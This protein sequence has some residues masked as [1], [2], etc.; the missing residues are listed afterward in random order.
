MRGILLYGSGATILLLA[1]VYAGD[2]VAWRFGLPAHRQPFG[3]VAVQQVYVI[4]EKSGKTEYQFPPPENQVCVEALFPHVGYSP[5]W[6]L[7]KHT[8]QR[9]DI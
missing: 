5:C 6:Y 3:N 1:L 4:H 7:R 8:E 2:Y 9:I